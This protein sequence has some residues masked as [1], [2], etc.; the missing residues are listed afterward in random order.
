MREY[1][2]VQNNIQSLT[3]FIK[4][5]SAEVEII[6]KDI[7]KLKEKWLQLLQQLVEKINANFS[8]YFSAMDCAGEVTLAHG[9]NNVSAHRSY[10]ETEV[11][12][13]SHKRMLNSSISTSMV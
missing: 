9:K 7:E 4:E 2:D 1:E 8:S 10:T 13:Y 3:K 6:T 5:K 11:Y 12:H